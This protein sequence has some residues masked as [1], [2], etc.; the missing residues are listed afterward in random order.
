MEH[1]MIAK[2]FVIEKAPFYHQAFRVRSSYDQQRGEFFSHQPYNDLKIALDNCAQTWK[3]TWDTNT[4]TWDDV[5][6]ELRAAEDEY[7]SRGKENMVRRFMRAAGDNSADI[8]RWFDMLPSEFAGSVV[9]AGLKLIFSLAKHQAD[10]R[11]KILSS[12]CEIL[13]TINNTRRTR[14]QFKSNSNLRAYAIDLYETVLRT[15]EKLIQ[16]LNG[17]QKSR[18]SLSHV[19]DKIFR[20][21]LR[22]SEVDQALE[23]MH[24]KVRRYQSCL[25]GARDERV[26]MIDAS[27]RSILR[28]TQATRSTVWETRAGV[29]EITQT[30]G[31]MNEAVNQINFRVEQLHDQFQTSQNALGC[32]AQN[33]L[34]GTVLDR[35][36]EKLQATIPLPTFLSPRV[37]AD[38]I[39]EPFLSREK[40]V[41][42]LNVHHLTAL[43]DIEYLLRQGGSFSNASHAQAQ[44]QQVLYL[45]RFHDWLSS[46]AP[47][48]LLVHGNFE[49]CSRITP[50]SYLCAHLSLTLSKTPG[51]LVL[52]FFCGQH[53]SLIDP[54]S[55]PQGLLRSLI[56]Q[57]L[58]AGGPFNYDFIAT[59]DYAEA[60]KA[61]SV[62]D[63][64]STFRAL[65]TQIPL[66][67]R[68]FCFIENIIWF[69]C[70]EWTQELIDVMEMLY[71]MAHDASLR[72]SLKILIS[73]GTAKCGLERAIPSQ[74]QILLMQG[75]GHGSTEL[76]EQTVLGDLRSIHS[77]GHLEQMQMAY[78]QSEESEEEGEYLL[79]D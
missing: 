39:K 74:D 38:H 77:N 19:K 6:D 15:M 14:E 35:L 1:T 64:C 5:F 11:H 27:T 33:A 37:L 50:L 53:D 44:A 47:D 68:V 42:A 48:L 55:G 2:D 75:S 8:S 41:E 51:L 54:L 25:E 63:L 17:S 16:M 23:E 59:R 61:H 70:E 20:P 72:C 7:N 28:E 40:L 10:I 36:V 31:T 76:S 60:I 32:D 52:H 3:V 45:P 57:L 58:Y 62:R 67:Q 12:F 30:M 43:D 9:S 79:L 69:E 49:S 56:T 24:S 22:S 71:R 13:E 29:E 65:I 34:L 46:P 73:S 78:D 21:T 66:D 4:C 26:G 18:S